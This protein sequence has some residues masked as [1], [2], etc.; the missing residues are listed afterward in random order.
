MKLWLLAAVLSCGCAAVEWHGASCGAW[1]R[2]VFVGF[3][4]AKVCA[5][6]HQARVEGQR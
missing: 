6:M 5:R 2:G 1:E 3:E 4:A